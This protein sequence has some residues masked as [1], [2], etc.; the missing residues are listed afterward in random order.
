MGRRLYE[1]LTDSNKSIREAQTQVLKAD[2]LAHFTADEPEEELTAR[3][4][5]VN[6]VFDNLEYEQVRRMILERG[7]R[8]DGRNPKQIRPITVDVGIIPR[9][10]GTGLFT[11]GQ[12]QVLTITTLGSPG[13]EQRLDDLGIETSKRYLHHYNF[14]PYS[15][16][17]V[18]RMGSPRRRDIGHGALAER[19]LLAVLPSKDEFPYTMR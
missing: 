6:E 15:T 7:E 10:H 1:A 9:V 13:D 2:V 11:R 5:A 19:S 14:P 18:K 16:G 17:E 4:K 12:T 8:V 3:T